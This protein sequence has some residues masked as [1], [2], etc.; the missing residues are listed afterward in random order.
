MSSDSSSC[1]ATAKA[2]VKVDG[3]SRV[4][5]QTGFR[6]LDVPVT[7]YKSPADHWQGVLRTVLV[8]DRGESTA[9]H[10]RY[11]ELA[12]GGFTSFENHEHEHAVVVL[13]GSGQVRLGEQLHD[14][15]FGDAVYVAPNEPHQFRNSSTTE[16]F[17]FLC[18]VDAERD[19]PALVNE[20]LE[21]ATLAGNGH[22]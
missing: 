2:Q 13:R 16:P 12:P 6:W 9:F 7:D 14:L 1:E 15:G 17:G 22:Q 19:R 10:V 18:I 11:F 21:E 3:G 4:M 8:C 5:R 20:P